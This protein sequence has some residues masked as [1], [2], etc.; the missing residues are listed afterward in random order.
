MWGNKMN[1]ELIP[2]SSPEFGEVRVVTRDGDPWFVGVDVCKAL[3]LG[4]PR[5]SIALLNENEKGVH[6]M[7]TLGGPQ[8]MAIISEPGLYS[9]IFRSRKPEAEAFRQWMAHEVIPS[10]RKHGGYLT[11][12]K[13]DA[14]LNDPD[15]IIRLANVLK[16]ERAEK[17]RLEAKIMADE[18]DTIFGQAVRSSDSEIQVRELAVIIRQKTGVNIGGNN[19]LKMM[20]DK[21]WL[22]KANNSRY[23]L[24]TQKGSQSG[25]FVERYEP[26]LD[27]NKEQV[28]LCGKMIFDTV[29]NVTPMGQQYFVNLFMKQA[30]EKLF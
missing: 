26:R 20:R 27:K 29:T 23:N 10:I 8:Q 18:P 7:D 22:C 13:I 4:N 1:N 28:T 6:S 30:K 14:I 12:A 17:A 16:R 25:Y 21:E 9:L 24:P 5:S 15:E 19:L 3:D 11:R 2:F